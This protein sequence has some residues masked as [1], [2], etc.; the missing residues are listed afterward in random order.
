MS[1][2]DSNAGLDSRAVAL[3]CRGSDPD[4]AIAVAL[5]EAGA[6]IALGTITSS[7]NE[8]FST[9]S[10]ANEVWAM[11]REQFN[12]VF[13]AADPAAAAAFAAEVCDRLGSCS[14]LVIAPGPPPVVAFD[15]LSR[16]EWD[17]MELAGL[18]A[19]LVLVHAFAPVMER[20][21]GGT[22]IL[23]NEA[24]PHLDVAGSVLSEA[25]RALGAFAGIALSQRGVR[26]MVVSREGAA[27]HVVDLLA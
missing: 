1:A 26:V 20:A 12:T 23:V 18:T 7:Q 19:P 17:A 3:V 27:Q 5:A 25:R 8:E 11:G 13:E 24:A 6:D 14:A 2:Q 21:G 9:A 10:I 22:V 15:E 4:R 16:D